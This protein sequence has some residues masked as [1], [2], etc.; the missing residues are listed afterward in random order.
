MMC[1]QED[2]CQHIHACRL[3]YSSY[4]RCY[5]ARSVSYSCINSFLFY[6]GTLQATSMIVH[7]CAGPEG[8]MHKHAVNV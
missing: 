5:N 3:Q 6:V 4:E 1:I 8:K 2:N 7:S